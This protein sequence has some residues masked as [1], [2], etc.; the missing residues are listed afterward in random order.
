MGVGDRIA[1]ARLAKKPQAWTQKTLAALLDGQLDLD[2]GKWLARIK[3][4]ES[5]QERG[6][7]DKK[8]AEIIARVLRVDADWLLYGEPND[9]VKWNDEGTDKPPMLVREPS[10]DADYGKRRVPY[11]GTVPRS[12]GAAV[13]G[14]PPLMPISDKV[15]D[16]RDVIN[17]RIAD[18]SMFPRLVAGDLVSIRLDPT[19]I[20]NKV[21]LAEHETTGDWTVRTLRKDGEAWM[22]EPCDGSGAVSIEGWLILG[23]VIHRE[24]TNESGIE[25]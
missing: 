17:M 18:S 9:E 11:W 23:R 10:P 16:I 7:P 21:V 13:K 3:N 14:D 24:E 22:L 20:P 1:A 2:A 12:N 25:A 15:E 5:R 6:E 8:T 19:R 4:Y